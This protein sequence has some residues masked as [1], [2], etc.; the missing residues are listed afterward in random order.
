MQKTLRMLMRGVLRMIETKRKVYFVYD[1]TNKCYMTK[2][3]K[4][5]PRWAQENTNSIKDAVMFTKPLAR[6]MDDVS[7]LMS[8]LGSCQDRELEIRPAYVVIN[9]NWHEVN[10]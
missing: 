10:E 7:R 1:L 9:T 2:W 4:N 5:N 6:L 8:C 3:N